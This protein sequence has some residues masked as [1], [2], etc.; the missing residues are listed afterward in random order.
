MRY[1]QQA[2]GRVAVANTVSAAILAVIVR[3]LVV[4]ELVLFVVV[5]LRDAGLVNRSVD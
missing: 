1:A 5:R 2:C 3:C 4:G